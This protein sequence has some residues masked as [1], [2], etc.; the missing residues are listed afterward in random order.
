MK[1]ILLITYAFSP[2]ATPESILS[3]KLFAS[4]K[5]VTVDVVTIEHP[6][7]RN[8]DLDPSL[9]TFVKNNF[10]KIYRCKLNFIFKIISI[11]GLK[12]LFPFPDY[13]SLMNNSIFKYIVK[14]IKIN[15]YDYIITWSQSHSIHLVGLKLKKK[16]KIT[17]WFTYF[18]DPWSDNP[19]FN[20]SYFGL[21]KILNLINERKV[22]YDSKKI[23][24]TSIETKKLIQE[25][26]SS[27]IRKKIKVIPHCFDSQL[28]PKKL[29]IEKKSSK[30]TFRY[31]GKFYGK[32]FP[33]ILIKAL[34][35]IEKK[36]LKI[37]RKINFE[38]FGVQN[39]LVILRLKLHKKYVKYL[40]PLS[41]SRSL[42]IMKT[43]DYLMVIDAPFKKSVFFPSKLVDYMGS[44]KKVLGITPNGT[45][46]KI[47]KKI[48]GYTFD[49]ENPNVLSSQLIN[50]I[51]NKNKKKLN[52]KFIKQFDGRVVGKKFYRLL[53][54]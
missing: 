14:N 50:L 13:Y 43:S 35:I 16:F 4:I 25:K 11:I 6:I 38:V 41:Y 7:P 52:Y 34:K 40:G 49:S 53:T 45:S 46:K 37:F 30:V 10:N 20:K 44:K 32:R 22:F 9:E 1:K 31:I 26:Y 17:N 47:I 19:F 15:N 33:T 48:G 54:N 23:F 24:C 12:K 27:T 28:Y 36:K 8:I 21:E 42:K 2:Q 51:K 18:S 39:L 3:A 29:S 5:G